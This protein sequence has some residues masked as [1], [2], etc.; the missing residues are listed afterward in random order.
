MSAQRKSFGELAEEAMQVIQCD[1]RQQ[2]T[3]DASATGLKR[4]EVAAQGLPVILDELIEFFSDDLQDFG[5]GAVTMAVIRQACE[6]YA[7]RYKCRAQPEAEQIPTGMVRCNDCKQDRCKHVGKQSSPA[8]RWCS[9]Y[10]AKVHNLSD[11]RPR[12]REVR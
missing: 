2:S 8:W 4:L 7:Y 1:C 3:H 5:S 10:T 11:Y 12:N 9:D 6:W